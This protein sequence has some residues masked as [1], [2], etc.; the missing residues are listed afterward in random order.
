MSV[1]NISVS[2]ISGSSISA[3]KS[4]QSL[5]SPTARSTCSSSAS[6]GES[7][8]SS[9]GPGSGSGAGF[10]SESR[11]SGNGELSSKRISSLALFA[12]D[13]SSS[14]SITRHSTPVSSIR[15]SSPASW[16]S[17]FKSAALCL[18]EIDFGRVSASSLPGSSGVSSGRFGSGSDRTVAFGFSSDRCSSAL[19]AMPQPPQRTLPA[20]CFRTSAVT[21]NATSHSGHWVYIAQPSILRP[22][23]RAQVCASCCL[24]TGSSNSIQG[25]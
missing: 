1:C 24:V 21:R 4:S 2:I 3:S 22:V 17:V 20:A 23:N 12:S 10:A 14:L 8:F 6:A 11:S 16:S 5:G 13:P 18:A 19:K 25:R 9:S 7:A 15:I